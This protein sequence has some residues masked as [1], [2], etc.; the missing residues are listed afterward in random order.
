MNNQTAENIFKEYRSKLKRAYTIAWIVYFVLCAACFAFIDALSICLFIA[1]LLIVGRIMNNYFWRKYIAVILLDD[2]DAP[3]YRDVVAAGQ[4]APKSPLVAMES[5]FFCGN[6]EGALSIGEAL[7][8]SKDFAKKN[9]DLTLLLLAE[10]N[11]IIGDDEALASACKRFRE[12][13]LPRIKTKQTKRMIACIENYEKYL[14]GD[15]EALLRPTGNK[16][17]DALFNIMRSYREVRIAL[18]RGEKDKARAICSGLSVAADKTVVG[19]LS[20]SIVDSIDNDSDFRESAASFPNEQIDTDALTAGYAEAKKK[21][22]KSLAIPL[23]ILAVA[24]IIML[25]DSIENWQWNHEERITV[26]LIDD[27]FRDVEILGFMYIDDDEVLFFADAAE[28]L[29]LGGRHLDEN[30]E[31]QANIYG[32]CPIEDLMGDR[33]YRSSYIKYDNSKQMFFCFSDDFSMRSYEGALFTEHYVI[34]E[35]GFMVLIIDDKVIE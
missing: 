16:R 32:Y 21:H 10:Y 33:I 34:E 1:L 17:K 15:F 4:I 20:K 25:P 7:L 8:K 35:L 24:L 3:L 13:K 22:K 14:A 2:L 18:C 30:G 31:W 9:A 12:L 5:E 27:A 19:M 23:I 29:L 28:G 26:R 11:F 6:V